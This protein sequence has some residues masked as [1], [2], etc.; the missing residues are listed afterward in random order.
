MCFFPADF[1][2]FMSPDT[3]FRAIVGRMTPR[4]LNKSQ[5]QRETKSKV[6]RHLSVGVKTVEI[7]ISRAHYFRLLRFEQSDHR[8]LHKRTGAESRRQERARRKE[9]RKKKKKDGASGDVRT[10][11][12]VFSAGEK[13][14][15]LGCVSHIWNSSC[16]R[17]SREEQKTSPNSPFQLTENAIRR[18]RLALFL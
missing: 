14:A 2:S 6:L 3:V 8:I 10:C 18:I 1:R 12:A 17:R 9:E 11:R 13:R 7:R 4:L 5:N 16:S 15:R